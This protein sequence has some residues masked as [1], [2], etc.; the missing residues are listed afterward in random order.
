[1]NKL[2]IAVLAIFAISARAADL[3]TVQS[4]SATTPL[5]LVSGGNWL[6]KAVTWINA[7]TTNTATIKFYDSSANVT[8]VVRA[9]YNSY[10]SYATNFSSTFTNTA[11]IIVTNTYAGI[12]TAATAN[13]AVTNE[14]PT[15][16]GPWVIPVSATY[17]VDDFKYAPI[18]GLTVYS[19]LAGTVQVDY[20]RTTQ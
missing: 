5:T 7:N 2:L 19:T 17:V 20:E 15:V 6:V 12:Y 13:T 4:V 11:G 1:M 9:A 10:T 8:S 14:R 3:S 16:L 18:N